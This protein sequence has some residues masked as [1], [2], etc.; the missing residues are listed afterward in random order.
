MTP[1][2]SGS[3]PPRGILGA[4]LGSRQAKGSAEGA[5][6]LAVAEL[7]G[8][9]MTPPPDEEQAARRTAGTTRVNMLRRAATSPVI[10]AGSGEHTWS[11][12]LERCH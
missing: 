10:E 7:L 2:L 8:T 3:H 9:D 5:D 12:S 11:P 1:P 4:R 6:G